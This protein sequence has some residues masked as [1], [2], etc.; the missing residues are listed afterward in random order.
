[1]GFSTDNTA[2]ASVDLTSEL[3]RFGNP[4]NMGFDTSITGFDMSNL[5]NSVDG[6]GSSLIGAVDGVRGIFPGRAGKKSSPV[7]MSCLGRSGK[8]NG[9]SIVRFPF[10]FFN[11]SLFGASNTKSLLADLQIF[12]LGGLR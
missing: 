10:S 11:T 5:S 6:E 3:F 12:S 7:F 2:E 9:I 4:P 1:M 8:L